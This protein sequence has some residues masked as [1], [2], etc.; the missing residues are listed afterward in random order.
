MTDKLALTITQSR[1][2]A[3]EGTCQV[4]PT[5]NRGRKRVTGDQAWEG[6]EGGGEVRGVVGEARQRVLHYLCVSRQRAF[7]KAPT[8]LI[9]CLPQCTSHLAKGLEAHE[10]G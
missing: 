6:R 9:R 1:W 5:S 4:S 7:M 10:S 2:L 3:R 8:Y